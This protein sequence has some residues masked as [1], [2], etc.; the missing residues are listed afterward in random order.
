MRMAQPIRGGKSVLWETQQLLAFIHQKSLGHMEDAGGIVTDD[1]DLAHRIRVLRYMGQDV[2]HTHLVIGFQQ[3]MD[4]IQ[5]AI[6]R[7][8][9]RH[10][11]F[12][13]EKRRAVAAQYRKLLAGLPL[14]LPAEADWARHVYYLYTIRCEERD[15]LAQYLT[16]HGVETQKIYATPVP[17]QPCYAYLGYSLRI[18]PQQRNRANDLLCLPVFPELTDEENPIRGPHRAAILARTAID[19]RAEEGCCSR[20]ECTGD[21]TTG[22]GDGEHGAHGSYDL[23]FMDGIRSV[24]T[25]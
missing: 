20:R 2:K 1:D 11:E 17:M 14:I 7:V 5:A 9:L 18:F 8:R 12:W 16:A 25:W 10:L 24:W 13:I 22:R 19:E 15:R 6:L 4:P 23:Y 21:P 3:R